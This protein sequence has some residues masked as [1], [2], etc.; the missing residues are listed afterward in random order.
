MAY[1]LRWGHAVVLGSTNMS[2]VLRLFRL[3][4][5][6]CVL[7]LGTAKWAQAQESFTISDIVIEGNQR[8]SSE[9]VFAYLPVLVGD[10]ITESQFSNLIKTL[11]NTQLFEDVAIERQGDE[12]KITVAENPI[13]NR[14]NIEGNDALS[15][16]RLMEELDIQPRRVFT[17]SVALDATDKLLK[18]Y[19][20]SG[21]FAARVEPKII[22]LEN[23]RVNLVFEV[24]EG[25]LVK[26][27]SIRF[28]GNDNFSDF[29]LRQVISSREKR[30]WAIL[31]SADKYDE[32]RL[33]YDVRLL[34]QFYLSRGYADVDVRRVQGGLLPDR[35]GFAITFEISEGV[36]YRLQDVNFISEIEDADITA[37]RDEIPLEQGDWYD[38]RY[39]EQ[40][41]VNITNALGNQGYSF[42]NI[43]PEIET[44]EEEAVLNL[45]VNIGAAQKNYIERIEVVNNTRT[46]DRV[47]RREFELVEGDAFNQ[48]KLDRSLRNVRNLGYFRNVE[49]ET[50]QGSTADQTIVRV[51]VEEQPTGD[52]S[53]GA[54]YSSLDKTTFSFGVNEKNFLGTGRALNLS[55]SFSDTRADYSL[56]LTEPYF[57]N[58]DLRGTAELFS[59]QAKSNSFT[60]TS[61]GL[62][63]G[64]G[65][66]AANDIY[67]NI[68][69][70]YSNTTSRQK[71]TT[72]SSVTGEE[73][74]T[75]TG[76]SVTYTLGRS[77]L[78]N[79]FDPTEG[80]LAQITETYSG[81]GGNVNYLKSQVSLGY[82]KPYMFNR[83][84]LGLRGGLG[85]VDGLG[86]KVTQSNRF[87]IG[88]RQVRGF[89]G[90]GIGPRDE[91]TLAAVGGN[92]MYSGSAEIVSSLGF[93]KDL[94]LRWTVYSDIGSTW[95]T[96][97]KTGVIGANDNKLR[98]SVGFGLLWD[99]AIGP[100]SF[101]W[102]DAVS[103]KS[104]D[105]VKRFQFNIGTRF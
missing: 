81:L 102:A 8:V 2:G 95:G 48:L 86:D 92:N 5:M 94:G 49:L 87:F 62:G 56:G 14:V 20:L 35:T 40:G 24:D 4:L 32:G 44:L 51:D 60:T 30:W 77:T 36:R 27:E 10:E 52:L 75:L 50:E 68:K 63:L 19:E 57:L 73:N 46:L 89:E 17:Q 15:D 91:T 100:L 41:L 74:K 29:S 43:T 33:N 18:I 80:S 101:Y 78:N 12:I 82:Y 72:S 25:P 59:E 79:R 104:Y 3:G 61:K 47:V 21:R 42:V 28:I 7:V 103:K 99:T 16:E 64:V 98:Q 9:T 45:T 53:V 88:G 71:N 6:L 85:N 65:F 97:Y 67:H 38:V 54:G 90:G 105:K 76:S 93:S 26:I 69:Y 1:D 84:V 83:L 31:S 70:E 96:D 23:N 11:Y 66:N 22:R 34:R 39:V 55:T 58:R 13:I 37:L